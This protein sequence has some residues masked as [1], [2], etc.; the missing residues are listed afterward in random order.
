MLVKVI[1][2]RR[3]VDAVSHLEEDLQ[4]VGPQ[5]QTIVRAAEIEADVFAELAL[6]VLALM[7]ELVADRFGGPEPFWR[8]AGPYYPRDLVAVAAG[9][10]RN[11]RFAARAREC[12]RRVLRLGRG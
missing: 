1:A 4:I 6:R 10:E 12:I 7:S 8:G 9:W 3:L 11:H 5:V 2:P